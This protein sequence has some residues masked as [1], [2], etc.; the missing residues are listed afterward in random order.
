MLAQVPPT[1]LLHR[2]A[3][4]HGI[5]NRV[6]LVEKGNTCRKVERGRAVRD[7]WLDHH[8]SFI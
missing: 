3:F 7:T 2:P 1:A 8:S 4:Q 5:K 6:L